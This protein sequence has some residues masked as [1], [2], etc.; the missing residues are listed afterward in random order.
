M[1][2]RFTQV[3]KRDGRLVPFQRQRISRAVARAMAA[4]GEGTPER[5]SGRVADQVIAEL[6]RRFPAGHVPQVEEIQDLV[7]ETLILLDFARTAKAYILYRHERARLRA[8]AGA[9]PADVRELT[10]QSRKYFHTPLAEF[11]YYRTYSRWIDRKG[12]RE[13]WVETVDR[14]LDFM[15]ENVGDRLRPDEYAQIRAAILD[16]RVMPSMRLLWSAGPAA[17]SNHIAAYNCSF[18]APARLTDLAEIMFLLMSGVG[19]G[20][21]VESQNVQQLPIIK[22][23]TGAML[24]LHVV[25]DSKE[26]WGDALTAGLEAWYGG[27]DIRFD[28]SQVRPAGA[29]LRTMGGRS[30]GPGPLRAMLD[31]VRSKILA[32]QGRRLRNIELHDIICKIGEVVERG[33]VRRAA[34]ISLSDFDDEEMR[35]A[36]TGHFYLNHPQRTMANNSAVYNAKPK[37]VDFLEEWLSLARS[38]TGERGIFNRGGLPGQIPARRWPEFEPWWPTCG[39]NP[40]GEIILRSKQFCNLTE[41]VARPEDTEQSL[42]EKIRL[43]A[44]LGTYQATLTDF[45]YLSPEWKKN[46]E[47]ERLLGVSITGQWDAPAVRDAGLLSRLREEA[48]A[49]NREHAR[50]L[51]IAPAAAVTCV[52]P[53]GTVSQ[54]VDAASGMHPRYARHYLRRIRISANDPLFAMLRDQKFP[55][56]PETG[57]TEATAATFVLE[58]PVRAPEGCVTRADLRASDQLAHW[59]MVKEHYTEHNPS[60]T[61]LVGENEW[62]ETA[63]WLF[64]NW[65]LIG[66]LSFLPRADNVYELAPYQEISAAEYERRVAELPELDFSRIVLYEKQDTTQGAREFACQGGVCEIDPEEGSVPGSTPPERL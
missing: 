19:V 38:G 62:I 54:L 22:R 1:E 6:H 42:L 55:H 27:Y 26:G 48:V 36:K 61:V 63:N 53:S 13:T 23:Q 10:A 59:Q 60:V 3:R 18:L 35:E 64:E 57:Q 24:P 50:R 7:E 58:F 52:K 16:Q 49:V 39:T 33:G 47:E 65:G 29:R 32:A 17:R 4:C 56:Y 12:R 31:D 34:L 15:R 40:C 25:G 30:S 20:F 45:P 37:A 51:G 66:G 8:R 21:S 14:Y 46:C 44:I 28:F 2:S 5:D 43:A 41:V 9:V 11:I